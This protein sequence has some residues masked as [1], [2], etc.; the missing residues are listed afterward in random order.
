MLHFV[1]CSLNI[2]L[3]ITILPWV[4]K[5]HLAIGCQKSN[6]SVPV[7]V[8][9]EVRMFGNRKIFIFKKQLNIISI[10][11]ETESFKFCSTNSH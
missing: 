3:K 2:K 7:V 6:T 5:D 8:N 9:T 10:L 1:H 11:S 4:D